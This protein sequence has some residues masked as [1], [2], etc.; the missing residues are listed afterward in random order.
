MRLLGDLDFSFPEGTHAVGRLDQHSEGLLLL[1]T[2]KAITGLLLK[3]PHIHTRTYQVQVKNKISEAAVEKLRK[4]VSIRVKGGEWYTTAPAL[5]SQ[6][7]SPLTG[8][9]LIQKP[10]SW[11]EITLTEGKYHQVRKMVA[12][13]GHPCQRL[14]RVSIEDLSLENLQPGEVREVQ[15][16]D[17]FGKLNLFKDQ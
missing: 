12:T 14:V 2:N 13:V 15:E 7:T 4:G 3:P 16:D 6:I 9:D 8:K 5:V 10:S 1:T 17:F 11:L